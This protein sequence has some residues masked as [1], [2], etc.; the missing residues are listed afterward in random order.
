MS[1]NFI[2]KYKPHYVDDTHLGENV[3][4][5]LRQF[6][7]HSNLNIIIYGPSNSGKTTLLNT[8][9]HSYFEVPLGEKLPQRNI[10]YINSLK[11]QG[12]S[13]YRSDMKTFC[14]SC[15]TIPNKKKIIFIDDVDTINDQYQQI[16]RTYIDKY[17]HNV[18][19]I[20]SCSV[21]Q[22]IIVS[23]QSR[24]TT[25]K[26]PTFS[27][28][29]NRYIINMIAEKEQMVLT[30]ECT[31]YLLQT[32]NTCI[33]TVV[34]NMEKLYL[35]KQPIDLHLC[36]TLCF[37]VGVHHFDTYIQHIQSRNIRDAIQ[38]FNGLHDLGYSV[39]DILEMFLKYVKMTALLSETQIY[40]TIILI[41]KFIVVLNK[42]HENKIEL[43]FF[44][45]S[46]INQIIK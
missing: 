46:L 6:I 38:I 12:I 13:Y 30:K 42:V 9:L 29:F 26:V 8:I 21:I 39:T 43:T 19:F 35:Y 33:R 2:H 14:K 5:L 34:N 24:L 31:D 18:Q 25:L 17:S 11:E 44:T 45:H 16:F 36:Q 1:L 10:L 27:A 4:K 15:S 40:E 41:S 7:E 28:D 3:K 22:K 37:N 23:L 32:S 20:C